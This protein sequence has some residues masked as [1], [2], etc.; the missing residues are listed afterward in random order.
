[1]TKQPFE[2]AMKGIL[3]ALFAQCLLNDIVYGEVGWILWTACA[4]QVA[5]VAHAEMREEG[6]AASAVMAGPGRQSLFIVEESG[7]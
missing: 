7:S 5:A 3:V 4:V 1:A 2:D 6:P